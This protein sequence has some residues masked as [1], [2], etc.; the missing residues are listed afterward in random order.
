MPWSGD[1]RAFV[2]EVFFKNNEYV[3]AM[4]RAFRTHFCIP[5]NSDIPTWKT[6]FTG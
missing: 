5:P 6:I 4:Q 3:I 1:Y 2:V